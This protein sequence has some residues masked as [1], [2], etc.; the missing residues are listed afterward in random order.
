MFAVIHGIIG[1]LVRRDNGV[2]VEA[3][4]EIGDL[5]TVGLIVLAILCVGQ[6]GLFRF[7]VSTA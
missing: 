2:A 5:F 6:N 7:P 1:A 3:Y 4:V